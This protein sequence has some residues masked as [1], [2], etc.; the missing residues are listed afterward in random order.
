MAAIDPRRIKSI[1]TAALANVTYALGAVGA[2]QSGAPMD[3]P[4]AELS[5]LDRL[6]DRQRQVISLLARGA[7]NKEIAAN[8]KVTEATIKLHVH[9]ILRVLGVA[10]RTEA[11]FAS[12]QLA[13]SLN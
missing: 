3:V 4:G 11:A 8:L 10:N 2:A 7:S 1:S 6:T 12:R 9:R 13:K 5:R